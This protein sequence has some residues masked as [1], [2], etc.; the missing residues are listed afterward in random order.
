MVQQ[1]QIGLGGGSGGGSIN[2]FYNSK[3]VNK[4]T[5]N[6]SGGSGKD[7]GYNGK[8]SDAGASGSVSTG[9]ISTGTY[10]AE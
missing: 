3:I 10:V 7:L 4:P 8:R 5:M 2:I 6:V 1:V 9:N